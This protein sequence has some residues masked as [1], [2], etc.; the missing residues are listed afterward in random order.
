MICSCF[1]VIASL[2]AI[3]AHSESGQVRVRST[4]RFRKSYYK[5]EYFEKPR[6]GAC[7]NSKW[8][9]GTSCILSLIC[10]GSAG[11]GA[12]L[13]I[14]Y[15]NKA[16]NSKTTGIHPSV[17]QYLG[18]ESLTNEISILRSCLFIECACQGF[19][20]L[21]S[22]YNVYL[23]GRLVIYH[24]RYFIRVS[25]EEHVQNNSVEIDASGDRCPSEHLPHATYS[26]PTTTNLDATNN[27]ADSVFL[28]QGP[29]PSLVPLSSCLGYTNFG[30]EMSRTNSFGSG[31]SE[32]AS[33]SDSTQIVQP[34]AVRQPPVK[35]APKVDNPLPRPGNSSLR[36]AG[37]RHRPE[38]SVS[39]RG[40]ALVAE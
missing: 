29:E 9:Y 14:I 1:A 18:I 15:S 19:L 40:T 36:A 25:Q 26:L 33:E 6:K 21:M 5:N 34:S 16:E 22:L 35:S 2:F 4:P 39:F 32:T 23:C 3:S 12:Y 11:F 28:E 37:R 8:A 31:K 24:S 10:T 17:Q 30:P 20:A 7:V 27:Y 38:K 13:S